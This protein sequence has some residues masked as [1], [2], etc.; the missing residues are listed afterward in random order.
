MDPRGELASRHCTL[1]YTES[2]RSYLGISAGENSGRSARKEGGE[3]LIF[4]TIIDAAASDFVV[5]LIAVSIRF[6]K[7][8]IREIDRGVKLSPHCPKS[9]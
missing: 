6:F 7:K 5:S 9:I 8:N 4:G 1:Q 2:T 3:A